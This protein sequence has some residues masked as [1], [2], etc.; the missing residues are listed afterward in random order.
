MSLC[1]QLQLVKAN[2]HGEDVIVLPCRAWTCPECGRQRRNNLIHDAVQGHPTALLTLTVSPHIGDSPVQRAEML[3]SA[4]RK[5]RQLIS[6]QLRR[7]K[8]KRWNLSKGPRDHEVDRRVRYNTNASPDVDRGRIA[9]LGFLEKTKLGEPHVHILLR[10]PYIPQ[11]WLS[12]QMNRLIGAPIVWIEAIKS[13]PKAVHYV[14]KYVTKAPA[15]FG[16]LKRYWQ[17]Q[18]WLPERREKTPLSWK[19]GE[20]IVQR[21]R[22]RD[23]LQHRI[24]QGWSVW[25][26]DEDIWHLLRPEYADWNFRKTNSGEARGPPTACAAG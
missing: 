24:A 14:T 23:F 26:D 25:R 7:P 11:D 8:A 12:E 3:H 4:W 19:R 17:S 16:P 1:S 22:W 2:R 10:A 18:N 20:Y 15:R 6:Q 13:V 5:M 21:E 9:W